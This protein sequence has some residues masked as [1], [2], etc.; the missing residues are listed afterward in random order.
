MAEPVYLCADCREEIRVEREH[1]RCPAC[2][3][4]APL[5]EIEEEAED[6]LM[7]EAL[8][9]M[10]RLDPDAAAAGSPGTVRAR[11]VVRV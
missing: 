1:G 4:A 2:G 10:N 3:V 9:R 11:F 7:G 5:A 6:A 8:R